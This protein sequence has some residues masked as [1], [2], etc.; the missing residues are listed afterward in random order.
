MPETIPELL[1]EA[2]SRDPDGVW[3]RTDDGSL[4]FAAAVARVAATAQRLRAAGVRHGDLVVVTARTTPP[5][6]L[7]WL[8][9][10]ALGAVTVPTNPQS[11]PAELGGLIGQTRPRAVVTDAGLAPRIT[12]AAAADV[13]ELGLLDVEALAGDWP[14]A[15][16]PGGPPPAT[17]P[18]SS[19][20]RAPPA[21]RSW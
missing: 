5:Y 4:T 20:H 18:S 3:L 1:S 17:L 14:D 15:G 13:A 12:Q 11:A 10:A 6:L 19:R 8:G 16:R 2:A 21:D 7:C 9:L